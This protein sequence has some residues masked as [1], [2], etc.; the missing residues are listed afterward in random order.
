[1]ATAAG[2]G[3]I[4]RTDAVTWP[5]SAE[6]I[7]TL[8]RA[9]MIALVSDWVSATPDEQQT[10][11]ATLQQLQQDPEFFGPELTERLLKALESGKFTEALREE[12]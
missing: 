10:I 12:L 2:A 4:R 11:E 8:P 5:R 7:S 1:M 3:R 9:T 6:F